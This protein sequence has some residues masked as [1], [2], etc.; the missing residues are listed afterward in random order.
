MAGVL[1]TCNNEKI[2]PLNTQ[3]ASGENNALEPCE[4]IGYKERSPAWRL[5][6]EMQLLPEQ[7]NSMEEGQEIPSPLSPTL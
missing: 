7:Q 1:E 5:D 4:N 3:E 2:L 6:L